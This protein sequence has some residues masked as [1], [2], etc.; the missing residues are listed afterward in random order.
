MLLIFYIFVDI[1]PCS[2]SNEWCFFLVNTTISSVN[3]RVFSPAAPPSLE[4]WSLSFGLPYLDLLWVATNPFTVPRA[5]LFWESC[6]SKQYTMQEI[7]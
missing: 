2:H 1:S 6:Q 3:V 7:K 5:F 4:N